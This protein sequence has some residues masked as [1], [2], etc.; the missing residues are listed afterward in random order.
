MYL[1]VNVQ[2]DLNIRLDSE[3]DLYCVT[4]T[5]KV[6][7][8]SKTISCLICLTS[9]HLVLNISM[10]KYTCTHKFSLVFNH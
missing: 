4:V 10:K 1:T 3:K 2:F 5:V 9:G 8:T 6:M 7:R